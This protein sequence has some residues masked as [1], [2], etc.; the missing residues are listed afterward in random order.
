LEGNTHFQNTLWTGT[1]LNC[2]AFSSVGLFGVYYSL[3][4]LSLSDATVLAFFAPTCTAIAGAIFLGESFKLRDATA[5]CKRSYE[6]VEIRWIPYRSWILVV[7]FA[8]VVLIARPVTL[9]GGHGSPTI[10][11]DTDKVATSDRM[12]AV[13]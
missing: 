9:F 1:H 3:Q 8:G 5:S 2:Y 11:S 6:A 10:P 12:K 4:Y 13:V 7:S